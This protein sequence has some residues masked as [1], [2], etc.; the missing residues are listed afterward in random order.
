MSRGL[1][2]LPWLLALSGAA[3]SGQCGARG[4]LPPVRPPM[5]KAADGRLY[6]LLD[7]G[8]YQAFYDRW[9][10]LERI[11]YDSNKDGRP[12][13]FAHHRGER[14]ARL[15]EVDE[16]FDG[17]VDRW[18]DYDAAGALVKVGAS[19]RGGRPDVW[20]FPAPDGQPRR[21]EYDEDGD[22]NVDRA[23]DLVA[24]R[25]ERLEL[26]T[27]RDGRMDRWQVWTQGRLAEERIDTDADGK[28]DRLLRYGA[29][30]EVVGLEAVAGR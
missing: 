13:R 5:V 28:P 25:V 21:K 7:R 23:E 8:P 6:Y 14:H 20:A 15:F 12:D 1:R 29:R 17:R 27:D 16:D 19:R 24:G 3:C 30:G 4:G 2:A 18:E 26:D 10:H 9:G 22:G 11:E